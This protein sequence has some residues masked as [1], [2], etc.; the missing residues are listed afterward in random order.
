[1]TD[2]GD[3]VVELVESIL[4]DLESDRVVVVEHRVGAIDVADSSLK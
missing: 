2:S 1:M 3:V 4:S